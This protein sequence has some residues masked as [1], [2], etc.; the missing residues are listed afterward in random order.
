MEVDWSV[1]MGHGDAVL[2][3]PWSSDDEQMRF[4]NL[5]LHPELLDEVPEAAEH[6]AL[7]KCLA[8]L[9]SADSGYQTAK[10]DVWREGISPD[11][12][13]QPH[14]CSAYVDVLFTDARQLSFD[15]HESAV[16]EL[17]SRLKDRDE[18]AIVGQVPALRPAAQGRHDSGRDNER[19]VE[20]VVRRCFYHGESEL[21]PGCCIT[22]FVHGSGGSEREAYANWAAALEAVTEALMAWS[23]K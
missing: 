10:C 6:P 11:S 8:R 17:S 18:D 20:F 1:E 16:R 15:A 13:G 9:N 2:E 19:F 3:F 21:I 7:R 12:G 22:F 5:K 14:M 4:Y 23:K